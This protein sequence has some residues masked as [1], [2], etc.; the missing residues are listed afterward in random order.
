MSKTKKRFGRDYAIDVAA[1]W[2]IMI[3][4]LINYLADS[5]YRLASAE[6]LIIT[7]VMALSMAVLFAVI[8]A[9]SAF[10]RCLAYGVLLLMFVDL[11]FDLLARWSIAVPL[12]L[13]AA[14]AVAWVHRTHIGLILLAG[15]ATVNLATLALPAFDAGM[16]VFGG[17]GREPGGNEN[18]PLFVHIILDEQI[19]IEGMPTDI[20]GGRETRDTMRAFFGD[21]GFQLHG[22]AYSRHLLTRDSLA[23]LLNDGVETG[24]L[25]FYW[26]TRALNIVLRQNNFFDRMRADGY[27][28]KVYQPA[29]LDVCR[30]GPVAPSD[31]LT[32]THHEISSEPIA[33]LDLRDRTLLVARAYEQFSVVLEELRRV[34][35]SGRDR[36][37]RV[38]GGLPAWPEWRGGVHPIST[39][40]AFDR[41]IADIGAG[42]TRGVYYYAHFLLPHHPYIFDSDCT[43]RTPIFEWLEP[44][45]WLEPGVAPMDAA[46]REAAYRDYFDQIQCTLIRLGE[47][48]DTM[49]TAGIFDDATIIVQGD[50][51]SRI[52]LHMPFE[53]LREE[54]TR[55]DLIDGFSALF[56]VRS[57]GREPGYD[58]RMR[59]LPDL[60]ADVVAGPDDAGP[61]A[62]ELAPYVILNRTGERFVTMEMPNMEMPN[63]EMP[64]LSGR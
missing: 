47:L 49:R 57:P 12:V 33:S 43:V 36:L 4:P 1:S 26:E 14:F 6:I 48:F 21:F 46:G 3:A 11:Q 35:M 64:D 2:L 32:Y 30:E 56:A 54:I 31:C 45:M 7:G 18:L 24:L 44:K 16:R 61:D 38:G 51:G 39:M 27:R 20:E 52:V 9:G 13:V 41:L 53:S 22:A 62:S 23:S 58:R 10:G 29:F 55:E 8:P 60:F 25:D 50:H 63:M 59:P 42:P 15:F 19:G 37:G 5:G 17:A 28:I 34:Y 40:R